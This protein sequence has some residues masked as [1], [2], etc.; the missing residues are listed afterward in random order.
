MDIGQSAYQTNIGKYGSE[1]NI[2]SLGTQIN[3]NGHPYKGCGFII[4]QTT[5]QSIPH[6][7]GTNLS[8]LDNDM[9]TFGYLPPEKNSAIFTV[10]RT[11]FYY[12][13]GSLYSTDTGWQPAGVSKAI[14]LGIS[15]SGVVHGKQT[16]GWSTRNDVFVNVACECIIYLEDGDTFAFRVDHTQGSAKSVH[17]S[18]NFASY[19]QAF[20]VSEG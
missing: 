7:S 14:E 6:G 12:L 17:N 16:S 3:I 13:S 10:Q 20:L 4:K 9:T 1:I 19:F 8:L 18:G 5:S 2:G 15:H 11:G